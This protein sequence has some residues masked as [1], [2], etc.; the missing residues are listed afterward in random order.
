MVRMAVGLF[1]WMSPTLLAAFDCSFS[2]SYPRQYVAYK[3]D[4]ALVIDGELDDDAWTAVAATERFVDISTQTLPRLSTHVKIRWDDEF[5]YVGAILEEPQAFANISSTCHCLNASQDQVIFHDNDFEVFI[6]AAGTTH[7]YKEFEM[8]AL[9]ATWDLQL[10]RAYDDGGGENSSRV[11]GPAGWDYELPV[12]RPATLHSAVYVHGSVNN[13]AVGSSYWSA[14]I[15]FPLSKLVENTPAQLPIRPGTFWR[16]NFSRVQWAVQVVKGQYWKQGERRPS[17]SHADRSAI[18]SIMLSCWASAAACQS[19]PVPGAHNED[20]W[21]WSPM[22]AIA[23][24]LPE[25]W[26]MLQF[27]DGAV[28]ATA[29]VWNDEW[30]ARAAAAAVYYAQHAYAAAHNGSF[31]SSVGDLLPYLDSASIVDGTCT[32]GVP[33]RLEASGN[34]ASKAAARFTATVPP[35]PLSPAVSAQIDDLRY[36]VVT[37]SA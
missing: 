16:I 3:T 34:T 25:R 4:R 36:L 1:L 23:M 22:G 10:N 7:F 18:G 9:N 6:D 15:A 26:G 19:C 31:T 2:S 11:F 13:P 17:L 28:N 27:A 20:N 30:P 5:L 12:G 37:R 21:V 32:Q 24:H 14:E 8:N 29:P 35:S 33:V